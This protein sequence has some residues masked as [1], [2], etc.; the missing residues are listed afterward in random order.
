VVE[1]ENKLLAILC[2]VAMNEAIN[3]QARRPP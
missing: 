3:R 1:C 2:P